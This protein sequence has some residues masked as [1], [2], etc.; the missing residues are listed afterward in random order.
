MSERKISFDQLLGAAT[1]AGEEKGFLYIAAWVGA[2]AAFH[3][4]AFIVFLVIYLIGLGVGA[5]TQN[6][7]PA[8]KPA[9]AAVEAKKTDGEKPAG[10]ATGVTEEGMKR[11]EKD[12]GLDEA[13][14]PPTD[15]RF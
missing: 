9:P 12:E 15:F 11:V 3:T 6:V 13:K 1:E 4:A 5:V 2:A 14:K 8:P 7:E 10:D